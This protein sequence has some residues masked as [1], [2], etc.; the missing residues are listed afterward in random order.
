[1]SPELNCLDFKQIKLP[2]FTH[3]PIVMK[4]LRG[5]WN[6]LSETW[7]FVLKIKYSLINLTHLLKNFCLKICFTYLRVDRPAASAVKKSRDH[8]IV[9]IE[10]VHW[11]FFWDPK[12]GK[13]TV[14]GNSPIPK[15]DSATKDALSQQPQV[16]SFTHSSPHKFLRLTTC[17]LHVPSYSLHLPFFFLEWIF[18]E[19]FIC[20]GRFFT[21]S[22]FFSHELLHLLY[23]SPLHLFFELSVLSTIKGCA[24]AQ[25]PKTLKMC[26]RKKQEGKS[27]YRKFSIYR[28]LEGVW[29]FLDRQKKSWAFCG[30]PQRFPKYLG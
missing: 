26:E 19:I 12:N 20:F 16:K 1:M 23:F 11:D 2:E 29:H 5:S 21:H 3:F 30:R 6:F 28:R 9:R 15:L 18:F 25:Q 17:G 7:D 14:Q 13:K 24:T 27:S 22:V 4:L 8:L 10:N